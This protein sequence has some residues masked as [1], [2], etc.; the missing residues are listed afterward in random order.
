MSFRGSCFSA[1][2]ALRPSLHGIQVHEV[3]QSGKRPAEAE[4]AS[5]RTH[6][7]HRPRGTIVPPA[8]GNLSSRFLPAFKFPPS[9]IPLSGSTLR[10]SSRPDLLRLAALR[11]GRQGWVPE[12]PSRSDLAL[13]EREHGG[14]LRLVRHEFLPGPAELCSVAPHA[15][16]D[17]RQPPCKR[18]DRFSHAAPLDDIHRPKPL[19]HDHLGTRVSRTCAAS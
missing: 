13:D 5:L 18:D 19:A 4:Q 12:G 7:I 3:E 10:P 1:G 11:S 9:S 16:H 14:R 17:H 15:M 8:S 6:L 2:S